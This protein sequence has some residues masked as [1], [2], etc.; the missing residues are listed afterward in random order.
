MPDRHYVFQAFFF[1]NKQLQLFENQTFTK[2]LL[3]IPVANVQFE[4]NLAYLKEKH[5]VGQI[6]PTAC[7][8]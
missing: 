7:F 6:Y 1:R 2:V 8:P 5:A 3:L 4:S